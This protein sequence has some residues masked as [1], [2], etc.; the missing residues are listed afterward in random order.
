[1]SERR[2]YAPGVPCWVDLSTPD[3]QAAAGFYSAL[4]GWR[5][6][7]EAEPEAHGY[8]LFHLRGKK[9]AGIG[10]VF[11]ED[12]PAGWHCYVAVDDL[13]P[14]LQRVG[15]A[16]GRVALPPTQVMRAGRMAGLR[17]R[18]NAFL[19]L[20][21]AGEHQGC[22][23]VNEPGAFTWNE[24]TTRDPA[25]AQEFYPAVFGW[26]VGG[27][28]YYTQWRI[29]EKNIA[30]MLPMP[31]DVP[32][33]VPP[34]WT[35]YFAVDDVEEAAA[36]VEELGGGKVSPFIDSPAGRLVVVH[37]P[38]KAQFALMSGVQEHH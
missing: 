19:L 24:L 28:A 18:E 25:A 23:L 22:E 11:H 15:E 30:G 10:P 6:G 2:S 27:D 13:G 38:W 37:D 29:D 5:A 33:E 20:W 17:D 26:S 14:V 9:V 36:R 8:G 34:Q 35:V 3:T 7:F 12:L 21:Q 4:F 1:M 16:G 31:I 32:A